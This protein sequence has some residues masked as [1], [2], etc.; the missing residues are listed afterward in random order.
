M[1]PISTLPGSKVPKVSNEFQPYF[2]SDRWIKAE[3][4]GRK[5]RKYDNSRLCAWVHWSINVNRNINSMWE[6]CNLNAVI[7][8]KGQQ[9]LLINFIAMVWLFFSAVI[10][11]DMNVMA[12][13]FLKY[14]FDI[15]KKTPKIVWV[16]W[17]FNDFNSIL[18]KKICS[19]WY[20]TR[21]GIVWSS[22]Y[23]I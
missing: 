20:D 18:G 8:L 7:G 10:I 12:V 13:K 2:W 14:L 1:K 17:F 22:Y 11:Y 21:V 4:Y 9:I 19:M 6:N 16:D 3:R 15:A 5:C 23:E